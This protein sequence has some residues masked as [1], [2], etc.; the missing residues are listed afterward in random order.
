MTMKSTGQLTRLYNGGFKKNSHVQ[1]FF[2][3]YSN[4]R[5]KLGLKDI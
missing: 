2:L 3:N 5:N 1:G 4:Y